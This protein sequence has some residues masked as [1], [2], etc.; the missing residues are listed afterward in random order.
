MPSASPYKVA[1]VGGNVGAVAAAAPT[2]LLAF[3]VKPEDEG[4]AELGWAILA[5]AAV[6]L[7]AAIGGAVG[8][9]RAL[10]RTGSPRS[11][12]TGLAYIPSA[13]LLAA[14][15]PGVLAA[16]LL[17]RWMVCGIEQWRAGDRRA[18]L[19]QRLL[20]ALVL[21]G[22][23][24]SWA[25]T[26]VAY[27]VGGRVGGSWLVWLVAVSAPAVVCVLLLRGA[28]S[29]VA[30]LVVVA[31]VGVGAAVGSRTRA[32]DVHPTPARLA[33]IAD[34]I[35]V[36]DGQRVVD[37]LTTRTHRPY[38]PPTDTGPGASMPVHILLSA[39]VGSVPPSW[40]EVFVPRAD[41]ALPDGGVPAL[42]PPAGEAGRQAANAWEESLRGAGWSLAN[43]DLYWVA[44]PAAVLLAERGGPIHGNGTWQRAVVL[45]YGAGAVVF[46]STRP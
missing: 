1:F 17:A 9:H 4:F 21:S 37:R 19:P 15:G 33:Q 22:A 44:R 40:P 14:T 16:P 23:W 3:L 12:A 38:G 10:A 5:M 34:G 7:M 20:L 31:L 45:P 27:D 43:G 39:P 46:F 35:P 18:A 41:G 32:G 25:V 26:Q 8:T 30:I 11:V 28:A 2:L 36:P 24:V 13:A 29:P 42:P 6:A